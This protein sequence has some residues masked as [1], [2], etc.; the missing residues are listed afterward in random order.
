[1]VRSLIRNREGFNDS[2]LSQFND[3]VDGEV[4][5]TIDSFPENDDINSIVLDGRE[6]MSHIGW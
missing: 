4:K 2:E 3:N 5:E 6:A 1:M